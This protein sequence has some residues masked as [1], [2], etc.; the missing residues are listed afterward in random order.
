MHASAR[1]IARVYTALVAGGQ[2]EGV[3]IVDEAVLAEAT[4]EQA[5]GL[6]RI[7]RSDTLA[8]YS[9]LYHML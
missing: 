3:G 2:L 4:S 6:D 1:G 9:R 7:L 5:Y 8:G